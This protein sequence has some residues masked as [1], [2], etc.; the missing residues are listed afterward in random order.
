MDKKVIVA[1]VHDYLSSVGAKKTATTLVKEM[2]IPVKELKKEA[3]ALD[4]G[5]S[6]LLFE[7]VSNKK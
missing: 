3:S 5:L 7:A 2:E 6:D 4:R 1:L